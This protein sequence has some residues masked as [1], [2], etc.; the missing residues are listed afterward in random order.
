MQPCR[1]LGQR[2]EELGKAEGM[3][4]VI[5]RV[6]TCVVGVNSLV[7]FFFPNKNDSK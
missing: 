2:W 5:G 3:G 6:L 7:A 1:S 4:V